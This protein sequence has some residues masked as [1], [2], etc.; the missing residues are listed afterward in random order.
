MPRPPTASVH[1]AFLLAL[2]AG[3]LAWP[4]AAQGQPSESRR[5]YFTPGLVVETM[6]RRGAC[7]VLTFTRDGKHLLAV[8]DDKVV[9]VWNFTPGEALKPADKPLLRWRTWHE[10]RGNI[11]ALALSPGEQ[12]YV[13]IGGN[14]MSSR[15]SSVAVLDRLDATIKHAFTGSENTTHGTIWSMA[16]ARS[17]KQ[18]A[19]GAQDG[20]VWVWDLEEGKETEPRCL[21]AHG[22]AAYDYVRLVHYL[23]PNRLLSVAQSGQVREWTIPNPSGKARSRVLFQSELTSVHRA[24]VSPDGSWLA[25]TPERGLP[26][27]EFRSLPDGGTSRLVNFPNGHYPNSIAFGQHNQVAVGVRVITLPVRGANNFFNVIEGKVYFCDPT[28]PRARP[29]NEITVSYTPE[30]VALH[31]NGNHLAIAGGEDHQV[32]VWDLRTLRK[33]GEVRGPGRGLWQV[34]LS[35]DARYLGLKDQRNPNPPSPNQRGSGDW[36]VFDLQERA[37]AQPGAINPR[38]PADNEGG[39]KILHSLSPE[40]RGDDLPPL[41]ERQNAYIWFVRS[42]AGKIFKLPLHPERDKLPR[43]YLFLPATKDKPVRLAV[44]HLWG[45]TIFDLTA[46]GPKARRMLRGH[47]GEV[48]AMAVAADQQRLVSASRDQTV[49]AWSLEEWPSHPELG[50]RFFVRQGRLFVDEIDAGS[51]AWESGLAK[52]DELLL[53]VVDRKVIF[54]RTAKYAKGKEVG[55]A[56]QALEALRNPIPGK[57]LYFAWKR[58]GDDTLIEQLSSVWQRPLWRFFPTHDGE[59]VLWRWRDYYYDTSTNG[60]FYIGWQRSYDD[61]LRTP[62]FFKAEQF[63][64]KFRSPERV[65][66]MLGNWKPGAQLISFLDIDPPE[67]TVTPS[68][69]SVKDQDLT[70]RLHAAP[71]RGGENHELVRVQLWVND[72]RVEDWPTPDKLRL[73]KKGVFSREVTIPAAKLRAGVNLIKLQAY[74]RGGVRG[75]TRPVEV[76]NRRAAEQPNLHGLFIGVGNYRLANPPLDPLRAGDDAQAMADLWQR[77]ARGLYRQVHVAV[78]LDQRGTRDNILKQLKALEGKVKPDDRLIFHLGGHGTRVEE[79]RKVLKVPEDQLRG[80]GAFLFCCAD[81]DIKRLRETTISFEELYDV[82]VRLP[83][84]KVLMLDACHS[85]GTPIGLK[86]VGAGPVRLPRTTEEANPVRILTQDGVGPIIMAACGPEES[87]Y[88]DGTVD[89]GRTFGLFAAAI[90]RTFEE[91]FEQADRN[92]N[93]ALEP[94]ELFS[95]VSAQVEALLSVLRTDGVLN[96]RDQQ[97]PIAFLPSLGEDLRL[98]R[99]PAEN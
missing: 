1:L 2:G 87:A 63:R 69:T 18:V 20:S 4:G 26:R 49:S 14:G 70:V 83:C 37:W 61:P 9:R 51:P 92:K 41:S 50:G 76:K 12:R 10:S 31:P 38:P 21:G 29:V 43:C 33:V 47:E 71:T 13:A 45:I 86:A 36:R 35:P 52:G 54:N 80:L 7:D 17:G 64:R 89:F 91:R 15:G 68:A 5:E 8:G 39:W 56:A 93:K 22:E 6:A 53:V 11:Y 58:E 96:E 78:L 67:V 23:G 55:T 44:G 65:A 66:A 81:F 32:V 99:K 28:S 34:A 88:E 30:A 24:V 57:E 94:A 46:K 79:L 60:D 19:Y 42:P 73:D 3:G 25:L 77:G 85:G 27:V 75:E 97:N 82:F 16:F 40:L 98:V 90:R 84:H 48:M 95:Q 62:E 74:N 72:Y 59:W